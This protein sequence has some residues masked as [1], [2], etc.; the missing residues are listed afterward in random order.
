MTFVASEQTAQAETHQSNISTVELD[1]RNSDSIGAA[2]S[3]IKEL[4]GKLDVLIKNDGASSKLPSVVDN[5][6]EFISFNL[7]DPT[8]VVTCNWTF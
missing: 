8:R 6:T 2:V 4:Y 3:H 7:L 5:L 1:I